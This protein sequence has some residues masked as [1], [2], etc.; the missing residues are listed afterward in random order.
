MGAIYN[1]PSLSDRLGNCEKDGALKNEY[2]SCAEM[3][4]V[5]IVSLENDINISGSL[6]QM[7][8]GL[9]INDE[10]MPSLIGK[11]IKDSTGKQI[12]VIT[13]IDVN[14]DMWHGRIDGGFLHKKN[15]AF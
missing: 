6:S 8:K 1:K 15:D 11:P 10:I 9:P 4:N 5:S 12:G 2:N 13:K 3:E 7:F 14:N